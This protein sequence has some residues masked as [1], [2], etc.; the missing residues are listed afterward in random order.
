M[1][2]NS[3]EKETWLNCGAGEFSN[4]NVMSEANNPTISDNWSFFADSRI[5][6]CGLCEQNLDFTDAGSHALIIIIGQ[7][8]RSGF[9]SSHEEVFAVTDFSLLF[10]ALQLFPIM[11]VKQRRSKRQFS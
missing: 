3:L 7:R 5:I 1:T 6:E 2:A 10:L 11:S 9:K 8:E 4:G